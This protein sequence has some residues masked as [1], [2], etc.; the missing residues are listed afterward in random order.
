MAKEKII[1]DTDIGSDV[2]DALAIAYAVKSGLDIALIT[3]VHGDT[4]RRARIA[5]KLTQLLGVD[6]P[7]AAGEPSPLV[8]KQIYWTGIEGQDFLTDDD[9]SLPIRTDGVAALTEC[10]DR[11]RGNVTILSIGPPTNLAK[12]FQQH[13]ELSSSVNQIYMM[14][15]AICCDN[16]FHLNYRA[17]N[18]KVDPHAT[19]LV[20]QSGAPITIVTTEVCKQNYFT[21]EDFQQMAKSGE[22]LLSYLDLA[23][24]QWLELSIHPVSYL[25]DPLVV[26]HVIDDRCTEKRQYGSVRVTTQSNTDLKRI[27]EK[28]LMS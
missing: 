17:H 22:P 12:V 9:L 27:I 18:F 23:A 3:T 15:N 24:R 11:N 6:I 5:R 20:F 8:L 16:R 13:P 14:G 26:Q 1:I 28:R 4:L 7:I 25:Y 19:D 10:I 21:R 2:D